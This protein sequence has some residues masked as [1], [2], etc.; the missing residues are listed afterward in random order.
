MLI[1]MNYTRCNN[2]ADNQQYVVFFYANDEN[3]LNK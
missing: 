1:Q 2:I 3:T